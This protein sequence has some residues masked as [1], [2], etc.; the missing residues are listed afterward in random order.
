ME[1]KK[2][3]EFLA[4]GKPILSQDEI[5]EVVDTLKSG[6]L[7]TGAKTKRFER[8]FA[9]YIGSKYAIAVNSCTAALHLAMLGLGIGEGDEVI[10][11]ALTFCATSNTVLHAGATPVL[12]DVDR[13]TFNIDVRKIEGKITEKT[14]AIIPVHMA[15]R[16]CQMDEIKAIAKKYNLFVIEDAAHAIESVYQNQKIG[17]IGDLGCFSFYVTKNITTAEGGMLTTNDENLAE[18]LSILSLHGMDKDAWKRFSS[19]GY[20]HYDVI[21]S[22]YKYNMTDIAA[23][24]GIHQLKKVNEMLKRREEIWSIYDEELKNLPLILPQKMSQE[25]IHARHLYQI[26]IDDTKTKMT[27]DEVLQKMTDLNIGTGVHYRALHLYKFYREKFGFRENDFENA[28]YVSNRIL[29]IPLTPYLTDKDVF[30]VINALKIIFE[31]K[32]EK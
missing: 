15:G 9:N 6:W 3:D 12:V 32:N 10:V 28:F 14:K 2:R 24:L 19:D 23:S 8:D 31:G 11:P 17:N 7:G 29:S 30:D 18:K 4:F 27:R 26:L 13:K 16:S 21:Y 25:G 5:D 22:G 20:K 1:Y